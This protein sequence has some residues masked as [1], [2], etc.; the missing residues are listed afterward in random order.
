MTA[1]EPAVAWHLLILSSFLPQIFWRPLL[2][3]TV[4]AFPF[5]SLGDA[6]VLSRF[7]HIQLF[8]TPWTVALQAGDSQ[9]RILEWVAMPSSRGSSQPR[10]QTQISYVSC[11]GRQLLY[12]YRHL[13]SPL[14]GK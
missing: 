4:P 12:Q 14:R 3:A 8:V 1:P 10:Y 6:C 7:S 5:W 11:I 9:A 2:L 13:R